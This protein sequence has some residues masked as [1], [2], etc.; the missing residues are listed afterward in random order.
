[1]KLYL[2]IIIC[3]Q[4]STNN[5]FNINLQAGKDQVMGNNEKIKYVYWEDG[6]FWI[7]Y[8]EEYPDYMTQGESKEELQENLRDIYK[9][10]S[11]GNIP[12]YSQTQ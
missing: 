10:L 5:F 6:S 4:I 7:G 3:L 1:M 8:L 2:R 12:T 9:E 11:R